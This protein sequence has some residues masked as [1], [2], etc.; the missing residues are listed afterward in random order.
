[1]PKLIIAPALL[2]KTKYE[3]QKKLKIAGPFVTRAQIDVM[4]DEFVPNI[5][6][7]DSIDV[8]TKLK[9]EIQLM[10]KDPESYLTHFPQAWMFIF[11]YESLKSSKKIK[12]LIKKIRK[13]K[14]K[15]GIAVNPETKP[16]KIKPFLDLV[17]LVLIMTVNPGFG[18]QKF[19]SYTLPKIR[20]LRHW[21]KSIDIEVDGGIN[22]ETAAKAVQA[23]ANVLVAGSSLFKAK[24]F[25]KAV[26][27]LKA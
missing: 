7:Q 2:C 25:G 13:M 12:D 10:V 8:E 17:D 5:T 20:K 16:E 23:G 24:D 6:I 9:L 26:K 19:L 22:N 4:D 21:N 15:V 11:H 27:E 14:K 1:M 18:G 3:L